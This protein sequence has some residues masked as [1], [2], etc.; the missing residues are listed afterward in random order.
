MYYYINTVHLLLVTISSMLY[1]EA[2]KLL[3]DTLWHISQE[4]MP[5]A[6]EDLF[7]PAEIS[8]VAERIMLLKWLKTWQTQ[9][10][11]A[12][13]LWISVTTVSRGARVLKYGRGV[14]EKYL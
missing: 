12:E 3:A 1:P 14:I 4:D 8:E 2:L 13:D 7:T 6:I 11:V 5:W 10:A 9:R